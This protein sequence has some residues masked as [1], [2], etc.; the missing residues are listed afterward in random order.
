MTESRI[1]LI[2]II[3]GIFIVYPSVII[4]LSQ[5]FNPIGYFEAL[6][7]SFVVRVFKYNTIQININR[8]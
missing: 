2:M 5:L 1:R 4:L 6:L 8:K 7:Y 3:L